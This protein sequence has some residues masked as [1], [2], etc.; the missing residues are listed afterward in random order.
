MFDPFR[1]IKSISSNEKKFWQSNEGRGK[2]RLMFELE[3]GIV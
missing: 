1:L 2:R 3:N